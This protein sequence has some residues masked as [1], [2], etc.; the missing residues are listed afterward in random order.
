MLQRQELGLEQKPGLEL[1]EIE[2]EL[3][4]ELCGDAIG[5]GIGI[6]IE[7]ELC[8]NKIEQMKP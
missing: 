7:K 5:I 2:L 6:G 4:L 3:E 1:G 8:T